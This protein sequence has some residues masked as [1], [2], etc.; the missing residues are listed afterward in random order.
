MIYKSPFEI[1]DAVENLNMDVT[2][3]IDQGN[4]R[5]Y[6]ASILNHSG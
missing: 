1:K 6:M 3:L 4:G 5:H 2:P